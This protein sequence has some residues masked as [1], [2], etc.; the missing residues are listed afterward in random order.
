MFTTTVAGLGAAFGSWLLRESDQW[1]S[2][3]LANVAVA[4]FLLVPGEFL[5]TG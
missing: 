2:S 4:I 3:T 5:L 1:W